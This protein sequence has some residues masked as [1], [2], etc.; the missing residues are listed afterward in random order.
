MLKQRVVRSEPVEV[1]CRGFAGQSL[2]R[3]YNMLGISRT[4]RRRAIKLATDAVEVAS[5]WLWIRRGELWVG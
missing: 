3:T 5:K 2:C 1:G 4:S